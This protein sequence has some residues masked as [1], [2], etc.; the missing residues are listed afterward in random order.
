MSKRIRGRPFPSHH[1]FISLLIH[2]AVHCIG[3]PNGQR[4]LK[5]WSGK[6]TKIY[7]KYDRLI[8]CFRCTVWLRA[9]LRLPTKTSSSCDPRY[10]AGAIPYARRQL[11]QH[12]LCW[13]LNDD[14]YCPS[15]FKMLAISSL[16]L[17]RNHWRIK[18]PFCI[19][20]MAVVIF[21]SALVCCTSSICIVCTSG[22]LRNEKY[23]RSDN[24][25]IWLGG[26]FDWYN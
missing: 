9:P 20:I 19:T 2:P 18:Y 13:T 4:Q 5:V 15:N 26:R 1:H 11:T 22:R 16:G 21:E 3:E 6:M 12:Y 10:M 8:L 25:T 17:K 24:R 23:E 7:S 14:V